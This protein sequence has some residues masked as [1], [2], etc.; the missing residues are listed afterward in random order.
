VKR[1]LIADKCMSC[2]SVAISSRDASFL[3]SK[4]DARPPG[5]RMR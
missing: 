1:A 2:T 3:K 5:V 4:I